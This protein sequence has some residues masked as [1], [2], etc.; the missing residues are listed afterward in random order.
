L[1]AGLAIN[2][3]IGAEE[4]HRLV[5]FNS[6][7]LV[8][9]RSRRPPMVLGPAGWE[10]VAS[11]AIAIDL[12]ADANGRPFLLMYGPEPDLR[13]EAFA[14]GVAEVAHRFGVRQAVGMHGIPMPV[15]H[16][17]PLPATYPSTSATFVRQPDQ[18]AT[19]LQVPGSAMAL[20]E[21]RLS[22]RGLD[23]GTVSVAVPQYLAAMPYAAATLIM[24]ERVSEVTGLEFDTERLVGAADR[25][26]REI[27]TQVAGSEELAQL[28]RE[29]ERRH[30]SSAARRAL[31]EQPIPSADEIAAEL[32]AFLA[33]QSPMAAME[34]DHDP[35]PPAPDA[36][37]TLPE[38]QDR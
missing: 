11:P 13:W 2:D 25:T 21:H 14:D 31:P 12:L 18:P 8:D 35:A 3:F 20:L 27:A 16:T 32:E 23:A 29:L 19:R 1:V 15:P 24:L 22:E 7:A 9:Y 30:D 28:I 38:D 26:T 37:P 5:A 10:G 36:D 33:S 4:S 17:R 6:D 34:P